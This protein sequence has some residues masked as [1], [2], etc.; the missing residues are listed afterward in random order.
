MKIIELRQIV[1]EICSTQSESDTIEVKTARGETPK[2]LYEAMSAFANRTGGGII[3]ALVPI[4][5]HWNA[6][7]FLHLR[8]PYAPTLENGS[9]KLS[10]NWPL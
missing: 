8:Q 1:S 6:S 9:E 4:L 10:P 5:Y 2:R 7:V 3:S